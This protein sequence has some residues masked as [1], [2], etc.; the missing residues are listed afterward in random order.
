[1]ASENIQK[2]NESRTLASELPLESEGLMLAYQAGN[3]LAFEELYRRN[4]RKIWGFVHSKIRDSAR[5]EDVF[6]AVFLKLHHSRAQY[7]EGFAF[8][9]WLFVIARSVVTDSLRAGRVR[10]GEVSAGEEI[11]DIAEATPDLG[12]EVVI[13]MD[14]VSALD[15]KALELRY[16]QDLSFEEMAQALGVSSQSARQRVSRAVRALRVALGVE[17]AG[18]RL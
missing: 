2:G 17:K 5:A 3:V 11:E 18:R 9:P 4:R 7:R 13:P 16:E 15:R 8:T 1:M 6:Q 14:Q 10:V 12:S